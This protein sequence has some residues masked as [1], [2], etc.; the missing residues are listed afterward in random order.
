LKI[1]LAENVSQVLE[2]ALECPVKPLIEHKTCDVSGKRA[3][4]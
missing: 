4:A 1:V 3:D 2:V